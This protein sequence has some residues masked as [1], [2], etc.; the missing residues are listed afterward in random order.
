MQNEEKRITRAERNRKKSIFKLNN[1][2]K[3]YEI[4]KQENKKL[5]RVE[6][7]KAL[8]YKRERIKL[9]TVLFITF[10]LIVYCLIA[11]YF[12]S[13]FYFGST[14]NCINVSGKSVEEAYNH[15][16]EETNSYVLILKGRN[17]LNEKINGQDIDLY[18]NLESSGYIKNIKKKQGYLFWLLNTFSEK[19]YKDTKILIYDEELL[20]KC[21][22]SL[23][24]F[25][26]EN[27]TYPQ[28]PTF[29]YEN[30]KYEI[31]DE[32]NGTQINKE[33]LYEAIKQSISKGETVLDLEDNECYEK[34]KYTINS[35]EVLEAKKVLNQY[36]D[37]TITYILGS[38][39]EVI[40]GNIILNWFSFN[41]KFE[42][43]IDA[44]EI[45]NYVYNNL[46]QKYN[47]VGKVRNFL[48]SDGKTIQVSG[49]D[50]GWVIDESNIVKEILNSLNTKESIEK[51]P[52][53]IQKGIGDI[54]DDIGNTYV[55]INLSGQY[56]YFYKDKVLITEG[57]IVSGNIING[58]STPSGVYSLKYKERNAVL[59]GD[60]YRTPVNFWMPFNNNIGIHDA[61]W[62]GIFGGEI[63]ITSG[64]HGCINAPYYLA[65]DVFYN[66]EEGTPIICYY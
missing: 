27:I 25:K 51:E 43:S 21:I 3:P 48:T 19:K 60:D 66:I 45:N 17:G 14:I 58:N 55:E 31:I 16:K 15:V 33:K 26:E 57:D 53:Y 52:E 56:L 35:K 22:E 37:I 64:S 30:N 62:R 6:R 8:Q 2:I 54:N 49:G 44:N 4:E 18:C 1:V 9:R 23:G 41:D 38:K 47:T 11:V 13:H 63:Y 46:A 24:Y 12:K 5:T 28:N 36:K 10:I 61:T 42:V 65:N 32:V 50:Y 29:K 34:P 7:L 20:N 59:V 40:D 39:K